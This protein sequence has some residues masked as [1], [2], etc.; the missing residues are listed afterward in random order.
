MIKKKYL[1]LILFI[2]SALIN[3]IYTQNLDFGKLK[4][5][6]LNF[7]SSKNE[8]I[9]K[10][11]E[12]IRIYKPD[13][14]CGGLS[15]EWQG[16]DFFTL[17]YGK[18]KFT[19]N[20]K[21]EYLIEEINFEKD[22]TIGLFYDGFNLNYATDLEKFVQIFGKEILNNLRL[23]NTEQIIIIYSKGRDDGI[24]LVFKDN[25]LIKFYYFT[26]C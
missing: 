9:D 2:S 6:G 26:P 25:K 21:D 23:N 3:K 5:D 1:I 19:G 15:S 20:D 4:F 11:G 24:K 16:V 10:L 17:D 7:F 13:Y 14:D 12:P 18:I 8:I 22:H